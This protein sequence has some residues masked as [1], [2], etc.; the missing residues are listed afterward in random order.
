MS[1]V[2]EIA[3]ISITAIE[4]TALCT[5]VDGTVLAAVVGAIAGIAGYSIGKK[6]SA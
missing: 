4:I 2:K 1:Y 3:I 6:V 5:G